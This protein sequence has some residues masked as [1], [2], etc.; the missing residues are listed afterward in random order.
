MDEL[1]SALMDS[2]GG[3]EPQPAQTIRESAPQQPEKNSGD[4]AQPS[5]N[6][7]EDP[8][9]RALMSSRDRELQQMR[10]Q[11]EQMQAQLEQLSTKDMDDFERAQWQAQK[12]QQEA[13]RY[14]SILEQQAQAAQLE[15]Q[16][17]A[18]LERL[19]SMTG[20]SV[21]KLH[22]AATYDEAV[23]RAV[24]LMRGDAERKKEANYPDIGGGYASTPATRGEAATRD[25][26][27][28]NDAAAAVRSV[29]FD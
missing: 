21:D 3:D 19:S 10:Q 25:A 12:A 8:N 9:V 6:L 26:L 20:V 15:Q 29:L 23:E 13:M 17:R 14:R 16:K 11:Y 1:T 27:R 22:D 24:K 2:G 7:Y 18:D 28:R 5:R 4:S